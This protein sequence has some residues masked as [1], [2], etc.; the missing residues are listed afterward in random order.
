MRQASIEFLFINKYALETTLMPA[1]KWKQW[2]KHG[3]RYEGSCGT[4]APP[5][6]GWLTPPDPTLICWCMKMSR[7]TFLTDWCRSLQSIKV[8]VIESINFAP[9]VLLGRSGGGT[10]WTCSPIWKI[11]TLVLFTKWLKRRTLDHSRIIFFD[12]QI[13][14]WECIRKHVYYRGIKSAKL[15]ILDTTQA[16][17]KGQHFWHDLTA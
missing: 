2:C 17:R 9:S 8:I 10:F 5:G 13:N 15:A 7:M 1:T 12:S 4:Q 3:M 6:A 11:S 14:C 16:R